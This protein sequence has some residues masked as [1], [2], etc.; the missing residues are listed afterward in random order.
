MVTNLNL[1]YSQELGL[2]ETHHVHLPPGLCWERE[3]TWPDEGFVLP[4]DAAL[5]QSLELPSPVAP[6]HRDHHRHCSGPCATESFSHPAQSLPVLHTL[7]DWPSLLLTGDL[8]LLS[9]GR[10]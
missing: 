4:W 8:K 10:F 6:E 2:L 5:S 1:S 7:K 9:L 3:G